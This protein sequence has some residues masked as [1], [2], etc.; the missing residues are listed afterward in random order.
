M[1]MTEKEFNELKGRL[2]T[3]QDV[4]D[5][6]DQWLTKLSKFIISR[7]SK[8]V[9]LE[10]QKD[11][12]ILLFL[13]AL[14]TFFYIGII[15]LTEYSS[16]G[17]K[18]SFSDGSAFAPIILEVVCLYFAVSF[19]IDAYSEHKIWQFKTLIKNSDD[20]NPLQIIKREK[21]DIKKRVKK[22]H[23]GTSN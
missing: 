5:K 3:E 22:L 19:F 4:H 12:R 8:F 1:K 15:T 13:S 23:R 2:M 11:G 14:S 20:E 7:S 17:F 6:Y 16:S 9:S 10:T 21:D 18:F